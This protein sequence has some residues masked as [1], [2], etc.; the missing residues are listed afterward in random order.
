VSRQRSGVVPVSTMKPRTPPEQRRVRTELPRPALTLTPGLQ[1]RR[2]VD[3]A[4]LD[5][6]RVSAAERAEMLGA[7]RKVND[8]LHGALAH[9]A[10][11][12]ETCMVAA[13]VQAVHLAEH[14][15]EASELSQ[16]RVALTAARDRL[17]PP[18]AKKDLR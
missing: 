18:S 11:I 4:L 13:A 7:M 10:A 2:A 17:T 16:A 8:N 14:H 9:T 6:Q 3:I 5:L 1:L 15:L 12:G